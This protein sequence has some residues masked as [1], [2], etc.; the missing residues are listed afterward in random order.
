MTQLVDNQQLFERL[1]TGTTPKKQP[2]P[3]DIF[4]SVPK[5]E[6]LRD[7]EQKLKYKSKLNFNTV[8]HEPVGNYLIRTYLVTEHSL[9]KAVFVSDVE[10]FKKLNDPSGRRRVAEKIYYQFLAPETA[11]H[12]EGVSVFASPQV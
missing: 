4:K 10:L 6:E 8:F 7:L 9:D 11:E 2:S 12:I 1:T 5:Y 3:I